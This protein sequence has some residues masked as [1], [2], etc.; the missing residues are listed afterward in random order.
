MKQRG[1]NER[2]NC[3]HSLSS[4]IDHAII[5]FLFYINSLH[6]FVLFLLY[7][8]LHLLGSDRFETLTSLQPYKFCYLKIWIFKKSSTKE[9]FVQ[10]LMLKYFRKCFTK[11]SKNRQPRSAFLEYPE[12]QILKFLPSARPLVPPLWVRCMCRSA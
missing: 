10:K 2:R 12:A 9:F 5:C 8:L 1:R 4:V 11:K 6:F 3:Q 7:Y